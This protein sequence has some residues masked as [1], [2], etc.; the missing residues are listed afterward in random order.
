MHANLPVLQHF[1]V[2]FVP[3][4]TSVVLLVLV[5]VIL[6]LVTQLVLILTLFVLSLLAVFAGN[7]PSLLHFVDRVLDVFFE[8]SQSFCRPSW[9]L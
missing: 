5:R 8:A 7:L 6:F 1:L 4:V 9:K 2:A 3:V